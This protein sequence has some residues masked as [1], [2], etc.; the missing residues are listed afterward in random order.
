MP[1]H[2]LLH[3]GVLSA[4]GVKGLTGNDDRVGWEIKQSAVFKMQWVV[5]T[6][7]MRTPLHCRPARRLQMKFMSVAAVNLDVLYVWNLRE[8]SA[9]SQK[10]RRPHTLH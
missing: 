6:V 2:K 1:S 3:H 10:Y 8:V 9:R 5:F 4:N 7:E